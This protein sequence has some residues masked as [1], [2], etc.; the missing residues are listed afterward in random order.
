MDPST[1]AV[2]GVQTQ[3][4]SDQPVNTAQASSQVKPADDGQSSVQTPQQVKPAQQKTQISV[5]NVE[6]GASAFVVES[7]DA[8]EDDED[9]LQVAPQETKNSVVGQGAMAGIDEEVIEVQPSIPEFAASSPEVEKIVEKSADQEKPTIPQVVQDAGVTHSG[10]GVIDVQQNDFGIKKLP[11]TY[12][13]AAVE[14]KKTRMHDSKHWLM[15]MI[16]YIWRKV[17]PKLGI[18]ET[19]K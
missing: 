11:V 6:E 5:G 19:T 15:G 14:E 9:E 18:K 13:Q 1:S 4:T 16:M 7:P 17:N 10:P 12:Q 2:Q 3:Q 8:D